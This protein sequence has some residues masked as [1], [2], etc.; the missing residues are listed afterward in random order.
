M[1][2]YNAGSFLVETIKSILSQTYKN[3]ELIIIDDASTDNTWQII[4]DFKKQYPK[5]IKAIRLKK[6]LNKG[7]DACAN[8]GFRIA[9]GEFIARMDAD[10]IAHP[11]RLEKQVKFLL[12]NPEIFMVGSQAWVIDKDG[13]IIGEKKVPLTPQDIYQ[14]YFVFHPMIHPSVMFRKSKVK[15]KN[16][17][18]IKYSANNDLLTFFELLKTKKFANLK[19]KLIYYRVHDKNDSLTSIKTKYFNTLKIRLGAI[20]NLGCKPSIGTVI[21]NICQLLM[22]LLL[23]EKLIV[24]VYMLAKGIYTP[25]QLLERL[26]I[27]ASVAFSSPLIKLKLKYA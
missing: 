1:P 16:F 9:K 20:K 18:K 5:K 26:R 7:G 21:L 2:V 10:D 17:Y 11:K 6:N 8:K 23:P 19:E 4:S 22:V 24:L 27:K 25:S 15:T 12:K 14:S 3:F 13:E